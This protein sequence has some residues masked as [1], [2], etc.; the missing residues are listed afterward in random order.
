MI[1]KLKTKLKWLLQF[2]K[3]AV[4][5]VV[6]TLID[7]LILNLLMWSFKTYS[8]LFLIIFNA[9]SFSAALV[10]SYFGNKF[11][12]FQ[13]KEKQMGFQFFRFLIISLGGLVINSLLVF[14]LTTFVNPFFGLSKELWANM[15]KALATGLSLIWNFSGY[16][17]WTFREKK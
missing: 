8:G 13:N 16:K 1:Q 4:V 15:S 9:I 3:Y 11:W 6:N 17:L 2:G 14:F 12:T 10:N 5:G 7:F